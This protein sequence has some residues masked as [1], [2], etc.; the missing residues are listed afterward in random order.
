MSFQAKIA[1]DLQIVTGQNHEANKK[2]KFP[3]LSVRPTGT[4]A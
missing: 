1:D 2:P 3:K 4:G